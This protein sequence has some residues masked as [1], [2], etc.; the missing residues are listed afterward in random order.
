[1]RKL[2]FLMI[3]ILT[4]TTLPLGSFA[5]AQSFGEAPML[6]ERVELGELPP[7]EERIPANPR[8]AIDFLE[9]ELVPEVGKYGGT[10]RNVSA[11]VNWNPDIFIALSENLLN[12]AS[13]NSD[14]IEPNIA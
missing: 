6:A 2:C 4:L 11:S 1:M 9:E 5:E 12:M 3:L 8:V 10:V 13:I 7:V 14:V